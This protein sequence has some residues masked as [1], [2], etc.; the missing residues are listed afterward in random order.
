M[1]VEVCVDFLFSRTSRRFVAWLASKDV[2]LALENLDMKVPVLWADKSAK[3]LKLLRG[4]ADKLVQVTMK[5]S[6]IN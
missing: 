2:L 6:S 4:Q 3:K 5:S 1:R